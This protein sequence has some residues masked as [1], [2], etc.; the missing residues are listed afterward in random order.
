MIGTKERK[1]KAIP[2]AREIA[3]MHMTTD[4]MSVKRKLKL[5]VPLF[6]KSKASSTTSLLEQL[7]MRYSKVPH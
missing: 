1:K 5:S 3:P 4:P 2:P 6:I 7:N